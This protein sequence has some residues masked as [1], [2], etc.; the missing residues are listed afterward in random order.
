MIHLKRNA[1][2]DIFEEPKKG[3]QYVM[4]CDVARGVSNDYSAF[5]VIDTTT[6]PYKMVAKYKNNTIKTNPIPKYHR[7]NC[8]TLQRCICSG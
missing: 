3:H 4:A 8:T 1:G 7:T 5:V 6:L 2:L